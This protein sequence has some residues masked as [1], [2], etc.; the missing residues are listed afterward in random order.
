MDFLITPL[1]WKNW[2]LLISALINLLMAIF[3]FS[4]GVRRSKINLYFSFLAF[5]CF[6]WGISLFFGRVMLTNQWYF[7]ALFAYPAALLIAISLFYFTTAFPYLNYNFKNHTYLMGIFVILSFLVFVPKYFVI[8]AIH[9]VDLGQYT[10]YLFKPVYIIYAVYFIF[11]VFCSIY[12]LW[13]KYKAIDGVMKKNLF[14][15]LITIL[16][17]LIFGTYFDLV[18]CYFADFT[19]IWLGPIFT[20][21]M[22]LAVFYLVVFNKDR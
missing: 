14:L 13:K 21:F 18:L 9:N 15:L 16:V 5:S 11:L 19:Y 10:L 7:W 3:V 17:G 22:N 1:G 20:F 2:L 8:N 6:L 4:R 12:F